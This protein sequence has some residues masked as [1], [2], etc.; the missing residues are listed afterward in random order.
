[1]EKVLK[2]ENFFEIVSEPKDADFMLEYKLISKKPGSSGLPTGSFVHTGEMSAYFFNVDRRVVECH[3][4]IEGRG[5]VSCQQ[6]Y[7]KAYKGKK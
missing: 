7:L 6:I 3:S 5:R 1:M 2:K 4:P